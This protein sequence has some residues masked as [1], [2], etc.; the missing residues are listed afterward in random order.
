MTPPSTARLVAWPLL[1]LLVALLVGVAT[2]WI[3]MN[4][5]DPPA[6]SEAPAD[7][8]VG[9]M[10]GIF[11]GLLWAFA[12]GVAAGVAA[13]LLVW[14]VGIVLGARRLFPTGRRA[15]PA[16]LTIAAVPVVYLLLL[17]VTSLLAGAAATSLELVGVLAVV[18]L[19]AASAVFPLWGRRIHAAV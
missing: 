17:A 16:L 5:V 11:A 6:S 9:R 19:A 10:L 3:A 2:V 4:V 7:G 12:V 18:A 8:P 14:V 13:A 15:A 1:V